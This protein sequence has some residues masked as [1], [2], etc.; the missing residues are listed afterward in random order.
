[1]ENNQNPN[2]RRPSFFRLIIPLIIF[3]VAEFV[4]E[5]VVL[6]IVSFPEVAASGTLDY[7]QA[8]SI[9]EDKLIEYSNVIS[10]VTAAIA[11]AWGAYLIKKDKKRSYQDGTYVTYDKVPAIF[12][13]FPLLLGVFAA[14][15]GNNLLSISGLYEKFG[16][17]YDELSNY[18]FTG[19]IVLEIIVA[20]ILSPIAEE[21]VF[22]GL[23][24]KRMRENMSVAPA[25]IISSLVFGMIHGNIIQAVYAGLL[26]ALMAYSYE[27]FKTILAPILF[28]IGA[29]V[30]SV[31]GTETSLLEQIINSNALTI[32]Y[33]AGSAILTLLF[34]WLINE[35]VSP[36][37]LIPA[38]GVPEESH[39]N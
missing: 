23:L 36:K 10:A 19:G 37:V 30:F 25:I 22:R 34:M 7:A 29:N 24:Y 5:V 8:V 38:G 12:F 26:G 33:I 32:T 15:T 31:I 27:R 2:I 17:V 6:T 4:A 39:D 35:K 14:A 13:A 16:A 20:G 18:I 1:M 21:V 9:F 3:F 28:H 11:I